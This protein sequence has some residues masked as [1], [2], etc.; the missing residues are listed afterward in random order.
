V[1]EGGEIIMPKMKTHS[2]SKKR[3][4][5][6]GTGKV[7][8]NVANRAHKLTG[9]S[10]KRKMSLRQSAYVDSANSKAVKK[11]LPYQ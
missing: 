5:V 11:L 8:K 2:S 9:K 1:F 3:L 4:S 10:S 7:K 6:T